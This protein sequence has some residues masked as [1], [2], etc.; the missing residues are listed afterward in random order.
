MNFRNLLVFMLVFVPL[1]AFG[2]TAQEKYQQAKVAEFR[3]DN[4]TNRNERENYISLAFVAITQAATADVKYVDSFA[5][6]TRK[7]VARRSDR[8]IGLYFYITDEIIKAGRKLSG[9]PI[10]KSVVADLV[11]GYKQVLTQKGFAPGKPIV[12][13]RRDRFHCNV[14][15][16][17][18]EIYVLS[19]FYSP[20]SVETISWGRYAADT[21]MTKLRGCGGE[22]GDLEGDSFRA[23]PLYVAIQYR[24]GMHRAG[25]MLGDEHMDW[26][27]FGGF[28]T[29]DNKYGASGHRPFHDGA[30][31]YYRKGGVPRSEIRATIL[32]NL[33]KAEKERILEAIDVAQKTLAETF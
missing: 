9:N 23:F 1:T 12:Q 18:K 24:P 31:G 11:K 2:Q 33:R 3:S 15:I 20:G 32:R 4:A 14:S 16:S 10:F 21:Y 5:T 28:S 27:I 29:E 13:S 17:A 25:K 7:Y 22:G 30:M 8:S 6:I 19:R 26:Y